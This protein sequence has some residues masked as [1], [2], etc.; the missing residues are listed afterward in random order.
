MR[1]VQTAV[2]VLSTSLLLLPMCPQVLAAEDGSQ[3]SELGKITP[4]NVV[5]LTLAFEFHTG[6]LGD[7]FEDKGHSFQATPVYW[8]GVLI[9]STSSNEAGGCLLLLYGHWYRDPGAR[10]LFPSQGKPGSESD[11][12]L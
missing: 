2:A 6:D 4:A 11:S 5:D 1:L 10:Q 7:G 9:I 12:R 3:Y 8:R